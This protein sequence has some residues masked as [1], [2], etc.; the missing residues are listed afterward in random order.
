LDDVDSASHLDPYDDLDDL[1]RETRRIARHVRHAFYD[2]E[3][4][5]EYIENYEV[6]VSKNEETRMAFTVNP[7]RHG[8]GH[9]VEVYSWQGHDRGL[10]EDLRLAMFD[11][12]IVAREQVGKVI[13][14]FIKSYLTP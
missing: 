8:R 12:D 2:T 1:M 4:A 6:Y 11:T 3:H 9:T 14:S 5:I 13:A 7:P 10:D